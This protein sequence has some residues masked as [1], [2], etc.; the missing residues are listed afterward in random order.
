LLLLRRDGLKA[1]APKQPAK[2]VWP[3][4]PNTVGR[5][6]FHGGEIDW[7]SRDAVRPAARSGQ[8][9]AVSSACY[10]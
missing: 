3:V 9:A 1:T 10:P 2:I 8:I 5:V 6:K 4:S 7:H